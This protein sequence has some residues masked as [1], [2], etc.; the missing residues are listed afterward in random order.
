MKKLLILTIFLSCLY[1]SVFALSESMLGFGLGLDNSFGSK[2]VQE[3]TFK[4]NLVAPG[5]VLDSYV[6]WSRKNIGLFVNMAFLFPIG[7]QFD[8]IEFENYKFMYQLNPIIGPGFRFNFTDRLMLKTGFGLNYMQSFGTF[9]APVFISPGF[10]DTVSY[11]ILAFNFGVGGDIGLK[12]DFTDN[13]FLSTGSTIAYNFL[14]HTSVSSEYTSVR[15]RSGWD[16]DYYM[17]NIR[18]YL[19]IGINSWDEGSFFNR[20]GGIGKPR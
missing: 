12:F 15:T 19:C 3:E 11:F 7:G 13:V 18:P 1:P 10:T 4:N 6:F 16:S 17:F 20:K 9:R 14:C 8:T 5:I 2:T